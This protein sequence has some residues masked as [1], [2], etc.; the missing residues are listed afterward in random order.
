[1]APARPYWKGYL[2]L[3]LVSCPIALY[4]AISSEK[5]V[6]FRQVSRRTGNRL[7]HQLVDS[8]TGEVVDPYDKGRGYE[9]GHNSFVMVEDEELDAAQAAQPSVTAGGEPSSARLS[10]PSSGKAVARLPI[11]EEEE[12]EAEEFAGPVPV[13]PRPANTRT[14]EIEHF[15]PRVQLDPAFFEKPYF[16]TPRDQVGQEAY[17]VIRDAMRRKEMMGIGYVTLSSRRRPIALEP[18]ENGIRGITLR[19]IED[20][21]SAAEYFIDIPELQLPPEMLEL[22]EHIVGTKARDFNPAFLTD[23]YRAAL[24]QLLKEKRAALPTPEATPVPSQQ[25]VVS[26]MDALKRSL[27]V[28]EAEA[29]AQPAAKSK[30]PKKAAAGQREMLLPIAGKGTAKETTKEKAKEPS[31][32]A[33]RQRKAS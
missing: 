32:S 9:V 8:A 27:A 4:P 23:H 24:V 19:H 30:K 6:S 20:M 16:V 12:D 21:R 1:L 10:A 25:N 5:K 3:S 18:L 33:A 26:L 15:V 11:Q 2:K 14:I 28:E 29:P 7:R 17:A 13:T 31:R 22:A